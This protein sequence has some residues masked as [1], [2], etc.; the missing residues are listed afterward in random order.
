MSR[1]LLNAQAVSSVAQ[2]CPTLDHTFRANLTP[3][4][5]CQCRAPGNGERTEY[6]PINTQENQRVNVKKEKFPMETR[7]QSRDKICFSIKEVG[8]DTGHGIQIFLKLTLRQTRCW[9]LYM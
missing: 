7:D 6:V 5:A 2:L 9:A 1:K 3:G 8:Q 4:G